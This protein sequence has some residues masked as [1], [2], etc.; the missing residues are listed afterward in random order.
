M[1]GAH[2]LGGNVGTPHR[3]AA[4]VPG[5][6]SKTTCFLLL[7]PGAW[8]AAPPWLWLSSRNEHLREPGTVQAGRG[9]P[10]PGLSC[11]RFLLHG[12][13]TLTDSPVASRDRDRLGDLPGPAPHPRLLEEWS[14]PACPGP[15]LSQDAAPGSRSGSWHHLLAALLGNAPMKAAKETRTELLALAQPLLLWPEE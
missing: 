8:P 5:T 14:P 11:P 7:T 10:P 6:N 3:P 12:G 9:A 15:L 13:A 1:P 2:S 4:P